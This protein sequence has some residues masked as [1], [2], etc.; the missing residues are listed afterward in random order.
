VDFPTEFLD[1][2][3]VEESIEAC[4]AHFG[5]LEIAW[6][7]E[8]IGRDGKRS[9]SILKSDPDTGDIWS[10]VLLERGSLGKHAHNCGGSYGELI[11]GLAGKLNDKTD[12]GRRVV[13]RA[14]DVLFHAPGSVHEAST[15]TFWAGLIHQPRGCMSV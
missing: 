3:R 2:S 8:T 7:V 15:R 14:G 12:N 6:Q 11:I 4:R 9:V 5:A 13:L 1:L 10:L